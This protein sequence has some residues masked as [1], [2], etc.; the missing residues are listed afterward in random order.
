MRRLQSVWL[1]CLANAGCAQLFGL[2]P[3]TATSDD[4]APAP[5]VSLSFQ[6]I[7]VGA[8]VVRSPQD[9][10]GFTA[11]Y[12]IPEATALRR[13][14][15]TQ[16]AID[17]WSADVAEGTPQIQFT[18]PDFPT[19][20]TRMW[21]FPSRTI[22]GLYGWLEHPSPQPAP[23]GAM[24]TVQ[25][26]LPNA[27]AGEGLQMYSLGSWTQRGFSGAEL[28]AI[29]ATQLGPISFPFSSVSSLT[30]RPLE[31]ITKDD[32]VLVLRYAG[33]DLT[34]V[35]TAPVF[36][37]TGTDTVTGALAPVAHDLTLS[38]TIHPSVPAT[39]YANA[40][41]INGNQGMSWSLT[42]APGYMIGN[43]SGP[44][45]QAAGVAPTDSG[46]LTTSYGN[47]FAS[48][49]WRTVFTWST[50]QSRTYTPPAMPPVTLNAGMYQLVEPSAN[51]SVD[52][53]AGL[54]V[55]ISIDQKPLLTDGMTVKIDPAKAV[56]LSFVVD[57]PTNTLYQMQLYELV[58]NAMN[59]ALQYQLRI[60]ATG[61]QPHFTFPPEHFT[62]G[63]LF[64]IRAI[65]IR[66][67]YPTL[68]AADLTNRDL[69]IAVSYLDSG[70]FTVAAP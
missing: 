58:P 47:P 35:F 49:D 55:T 59:T 54:P 37:Q 36:D 31:R 41:P 28:P 4:A 20:L 56:D 3:T 12:E 8:Q 15:A 67:G 46:S 11:E 33:N 68:A 10:T 30:G 60:S 63:H 1:V 7:S 29:G 13:V 25:V 19:P 14:A 52:L 9:L 43:N 70:A 32:A 57:Q 64:T 66:G 17:T 27:Y 34:G 24:L 42:A 18:L 53:D 39:R 65:A 22:K 69:P 2:E 45:L 21:A 23:M 6:R 40:R 5:R 16:S 26:T 44:L 38:L 61:V 51:A 62:V 48:R 50:G